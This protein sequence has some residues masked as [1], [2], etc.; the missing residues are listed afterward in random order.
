MHQYDFSHAE[1]LSEAASFEFSV[2]SEIFY[3]W[4]LSSRSF[5][6]RP[7]SNFWNFWTK[8]FLLLA[9]NLHFFHA[10]IRQMQLC[11]HWKE[12]ILS[13]CSLFIIESIQYPP[14]STI[15]SA[16]PT[17]YASH[18]HWTHTNG[19]WSQPLMWVHKPDLDHSFW[20]L[21]LAQIL[22]VLEI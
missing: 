22:N 10:S 15:R 4:P 12:A 7:F 19:F 13:F 14:S 21:C 11:Y 2:T 3:S 8:M 6:F 18:W 20:R 1:L 16:G 5:S 9:R 17:R